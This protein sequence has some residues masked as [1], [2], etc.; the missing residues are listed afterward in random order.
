MALL[1]SRFTWIAL[2]LGLY[3]AALNL[4]ALTILRQVS[5]VGPIMSGADCLHNGSL[6]GGPD[7][8]LGTSLL[9]SSWLGNLPWLVSLIALASARSWR[10]TTWIGMIATVTSLLPVIPLVAKLDIYTHGEI[11]RLT[12]VGPG[13]ALWITALATPALFSWWLR[14]T[15]AKAAAETEA[16]DTRT[17]TGQVR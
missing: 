3:W 11:N 17:A 5:G 4:H 9:Y 12:G 13:Y 14:R 10:A 15:H 7:G 2:S 16:R 1:R 6:L 8:S